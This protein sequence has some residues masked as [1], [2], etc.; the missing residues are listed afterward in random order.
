MQLLLTI[1]A[2]FMI[3]FIFLNYYLCGKH[4]TTHRAFSQ[5]EHQ[6]DDSFLFP[7]AQQTTHHLVGFFFD[8]PG[9]MSEKQCPRSQEGLGDFDGQPLVAGS[10]TPTTEDELSANVSRKSNLEMLPPFFLYMINPL[11]LEFSFK[12]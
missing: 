5:F 4:G 3:F 9:T 10:T 8:V 6:Y 2:K 11:A 1:I 12:F 7:L